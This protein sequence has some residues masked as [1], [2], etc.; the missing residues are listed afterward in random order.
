[1]TLDDQY[2]RL[3]DIFMQADQKIK[4]GK[5]AEAV[6]LLEGILREDPTFGRAYNHLGWVYEIKYQLYQQADEYYRLA[7]QHA[8]EYLAT[9][10]NYMALLSNLKRFN[11]LRQLLERAKAID[12]INKVTLYNEYGILYEMEGQYGRAIDAYQ[13]SI[14]QALDMKIIENRLLSIERCKKKSGLFGGSHA[15]DK[16]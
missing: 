8:P 13:E 10:Y 7:L 14:R 11:E 1:M 3:H 2:L 6:Q 4:D 16:I 5:I 9:Y 15:T 12:G